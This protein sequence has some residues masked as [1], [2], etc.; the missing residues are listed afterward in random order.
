MVSRTAQMKDKGQITVPIEI[1]RKYE[2]HTG[3]RLVFEDRGDY[4]AVMPARSIA[5]R[6]AG[7]LAEYAEGKPP[8]EIDRNEIWAGIASERWDRLQA[9]LAEDA[10]DDRA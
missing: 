1:R 5:D 10:P 3:T 2:L 9:Q 7:S 4:I 6:L 8:L